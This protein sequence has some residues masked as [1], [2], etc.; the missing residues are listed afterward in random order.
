MVFKKRSKSKIPTR[1]NFES[2][3][4]MIFRICF[5]ILLLFYFSVVNA[6]EP[7]LPE[8]KFLI[9]IQVPDTEQGRN[10]EVSGWTMHGGQV[11]R[12]SNDNTFVWGVGGYF[13]NDLN[14]FA[15][16]M[17]NN[18]ENNRTILD[19]QILPNDLLTY[20]LVNGRVVTKK[21]WWKF[22]VP[23]VGCER[24]RGEVIVGLV[25]PE[26][27]KHECSHKTNQ[28]K[29]AWIIDQET[30]HI[31]EISPQGVSCDYMGGEYFCDQSLDK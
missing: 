4:N 28:V 2:L 1:A 8:V 21:Q 22:Y 30:W 26:L 10:G 25:R 17:R 23:T 5:Y 6:D 20:S 7:L 15:V 29:R 14:I 11:F 13:K 3:K 31:S 27:E 18:K 19:A 16:E 9:G 12:I 24:K